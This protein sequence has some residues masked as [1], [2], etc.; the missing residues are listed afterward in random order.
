MLTDAAVQVIAN[1]VM[2][3]SS[4]RIL[5]LALGT[6]LCLLF[7]QVIDWPLSFLAPAVT[8][9]LLG[10]H[11]PAP[12]FKEG[13]N[14]FLSLMGAMLVGHLLLPFLDHA[15]EAGLLLLALV[16]FGSFYYTEM[17]GSSL[18]GFFL[19]IGF[20]FFLSVGSVSIDLYISFTETVA[21][22]T[23]VGIAFVWI[24][25]ALLPAPPPE[26][27]TDDHHPS[28]PKP[29][30]RE[31]IRGALCALVVVFP[32]AF[33]FL[34]I[35][36]SANYIPV[37]VY[38]VTLGQQSSAVK[39]YHVGLKLV[40]STFWGGVGAIIAWIILSACP[41]LA[42]Y[43]LLIALAALLYGPRIFK[44][45]GL[46]SDGDMWS[47]AFWTMFIILA[48]TVGS[49][50]WE[51]SAAERFWTRQLQF[52]GVALYGTFAV[53]GFNA[54]WPGKQERSS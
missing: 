11:Y 18:F 29:S 6:S 1:P 5:C 31:A 48:P 38:V 27:S 35:S 8:I 25:H 40:E 34:C 16:L 41:N 47:F 10:T 21:I 53:A 39:S 42:M 12:S 51:T 49:A 24:A 19:P 52:M 54:I 17:G 46:N 50:A 4:R 13:L 45:E 15:P 32:V 30:Q 44:G 3:T 2:D 37:M 28:S 33:L 36:S 43:T 9:M 26:S 14:I 20:S 23:A 22:S 7:S